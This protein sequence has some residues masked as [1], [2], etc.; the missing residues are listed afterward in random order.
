M[1]FRDF[2]HT[3]GSSVLSWAVLDC[4]GLFQAILSFCGLLWAFL[5][6]SGLPGLF[7]AVM[8][9]SGLFWDGLGCL[10]CPGLFLAILGR[11]G[12]SDL[13]WAV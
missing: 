2:G 11:L 8:S 3:L 5:G 6:Y 4:P 7:W 1:T 10:D 12:Y 13:F 9:Y